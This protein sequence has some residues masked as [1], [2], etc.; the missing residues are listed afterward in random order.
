MAPLPATLHQTMEAVRRAKK[1][2]PVLPNRPLGARM[3]TVLPNRPLLGATSS[4]YFFATSRVTCSSMWRPIQM[5]STSGGAAARV[6][7]IWR[8]YP[9]RAT[10]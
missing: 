6:T 9:A 3:E 10:V 2:G 4:S 5:D 7:G 1:E 8:S